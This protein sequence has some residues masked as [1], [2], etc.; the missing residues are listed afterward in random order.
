LD[1]LSKVGKK[2]FDMIVQKKPCARQSRLRLCVFP[3][4]SVAFL[5]P[6]FSSCITSR[7]FKDPKDRPVVGTP[8]TVAD[9][10]VEIGVKLLGQGE[11][12]LAA[13]LSLRVGVTRHFDMRINLAHGALGVL[14]LDAKYNFVDK[15]W[16]AMGART[17]I[18]WARP[19]VIWA[20]PDD[21][22]QN[23]GNIDIVA[24]PIELI[25]GSQPLK[26]LGANLTLGYLHGALVGTIHTD[27]TLFD[28]SIGARKLYLVPQLNFLVI[29]KLHIFLRADL[30]VL[31]YVRDEMIAEAEIEPGM[32]AGVRSAEWIKLDDPIS[33]SQVALGLDLKL[34]RITRL[35]LFAI[36][37]GP[38]T[39]SG[40]LRTPVLPGVGVYW[41]F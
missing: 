5:A 30:P 13:A 34:G 24:V 31:I 23:L 20:L 32:S 25:V 41:Q 26:W 16:W 27:T 10:D 21:M 14:N 18:L 35:E 9:K 39:L 7:N 12:D 29:S 6:F 8:Y 36:F 2:L 15:K 17:G 4:W 37:R 1:F 33:R 22:Q 3:I 38:L 28:G 19:R 40:V 11:D